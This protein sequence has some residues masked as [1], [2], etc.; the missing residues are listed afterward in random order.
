MILIKCVINLVIILNILYGMLIN[1]NVP[2]YLLMQLLQLILEM[3][4]VQMV[5]IGNKVIN[6]L[7]YHKIQ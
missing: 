6:V 5:N 7:I 2:N 1:K 4:Y 3:L